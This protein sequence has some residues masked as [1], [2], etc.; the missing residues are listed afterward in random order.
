M[1]ELTQVCLLIDGEEGKEEAGP[2]QAAE[3]ISII[4]YSAEW[5]LTRKKQ[6]RNSNIIGGSWEFHR[7]SP[8]LL[9]LT[10]D[11]ELRAEAGFIMH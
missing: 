9:K 10:K 5:Y 8:R 11:A 6:K 7:R 3:G 4:L 2:G 1:D